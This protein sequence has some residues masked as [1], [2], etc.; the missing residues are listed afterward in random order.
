[1]PYWH[2]L[3]LLQQDNYPETG[4][5]FL[6][7]VTVISVLINKN[8]RCH[9]LIDARAPREVLLGFDEITAVMAIIG[10]LDKSAAHDIGHRRCRGDD[11]DGGP[12]WWICR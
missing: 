7:L 9:M 2:P 1:M 8:K 3:R 6:R 12:Y 10:D 4:I 11:D 5:V